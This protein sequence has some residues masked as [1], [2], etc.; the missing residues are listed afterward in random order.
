[1]KSFALSSLALALLVTSQHTPTV[2]PIIKATVDSE[3]TAEFMNGIEAKCPD[4]YKFKSNNIGPGGS[5]KDT[6][7]Q[8]ASAE[9]VTK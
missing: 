1:M 7:N 3:Y 2:H 6:F 5:Y 9:C 8:V 4:G